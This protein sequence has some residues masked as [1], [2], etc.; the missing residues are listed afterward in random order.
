MKPGSK[1][2]Q[3]CLHLE[4]SAEFQ[5]G[6]HRTGEKDFVGK[7]HKKE[8]NQ[9]PGFHFLQIK[10]KEKLVGI[11]IQKIEPC[12]WQRRPVPVPPCPA[13]TRTFWKCN[14]MKWFLELWWH[15]I[16]VCLPLTCGETRPRHHP[17]YRTDGTL[18]QFQDCHHPPRRKCTFSREPN[19]PN[20]KTT[21][22]V[23]Y[24]HLTSRLDYLWNEK[25]VDVPGNIQIQN[26]STELNPQNSLPCNSPSNFPCIFKMNINLKY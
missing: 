2:C 16:P 10:I 24:F 7:R 22:I 23:F 3:V 26:N 4:S 17:W 11:W 20:T 14:E 25:A 5:D 19:K 15:Q 18:H 13:K 21:L 8:R 9:R 1:R 6:R 12:H